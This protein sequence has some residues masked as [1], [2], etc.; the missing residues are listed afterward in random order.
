MTESHNQV[1]D[2]GSISRCRAM[3]NRALYN[4]QDASCEESIADFSQTC[5]QDTAKEVASIYGNELSNEKWSSLCN[6]FNACTRLSRILRTQRAK[7]EVSLPGV[8]KLFNSNTMEDVREG[9]EEAVKNRSILFT[10]FPG[11]WKLG[12]QHGENVSDASAG[13]S[14]TDA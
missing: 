14:G 6:I 9:E 2:E 12:D 1:G 7:F 8:Q 3:L 5:A 10:T 11:L 4:G 13:G